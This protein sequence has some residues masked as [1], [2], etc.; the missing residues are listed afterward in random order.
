MLILN[1]LRLYHLLALL[2]LTSSAPTSTLPTFT[3]TSALPT[4]KLDPCGPGLG[5]PGAVYTC[6]QPNWGHDTQPCTWHPPDVQQ[7]FSFPL[8]TESAKP[9]SIG[10][11]PGGYCEFF[12]ELNCL[13]VPFSYDVKNVGSGT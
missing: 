9:K 6:P 3:L 5:L 2:P 7:C 8:G 1:Q 10:P 13:G 11:D 4:F 12:T